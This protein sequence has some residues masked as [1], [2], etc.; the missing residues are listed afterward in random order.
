MNT[1]NFDFDFEKALKFVAQ[2]MPLGD[3]LI[4]PTLLHSVQVGLNLYS[5][6]YNR[7]IAIAGLLHDML[8][9]TSVREEEIK[10]MFG[11]KVALLVLANTKNNNLPEEE[12]YVDLIDRC[13]QAGEDALIVKTADILDNYHYFVLEKNTKAIEK[14][15]YLSKLVRERKPNHFTDPIYNKLP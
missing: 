2:N 9:D 13:T 12:R 15:L 11:E 7:E 3:Q 6:G 5:S 4:K 8:E 10:D 1:N 14:M